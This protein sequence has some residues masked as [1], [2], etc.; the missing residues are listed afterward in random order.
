MGKK[1]IW[2]FIIPI[3]LVMFIVMGALQFVII[4]NVRQRTNELVNAQIKNSSDAVLQVLSTIDLLLKEEVKRSMA[5]LMDKS[6][7]IGEPS[8]NGSTTVVVAGKS[9]P[10]LTFGG[11]AS[12]KPQISMA[13]RF[14][15]VDDV[16]KTMGGTATFFVKSGNDFVRISTNVKKQDGSRAI[17]TLLDPNGKAI[18]EVLA[19]RPFYGEVDI[20]GNPYI[21]GYVPIKNN[22]REALK[23]ALQDTIGIYYV[24]YKVDAM[25]GIDDVVSNATILHN[26]FLAV[27]DGTGKVRFHSNNVT[28]EDIEKILKTSANTVNS[29]VANTTNG[30]TANSTVSSTADGSGGSAE[31]T[32]VG[33]PFTQWGFNVVA[34]YPKKDL[35]SEIFRSVLQAAVVVFIVF[36]VLAVFI[37]VMLSKMILKPLNEV[38]H[39]AEEVGHGNLDLD[40]GLAA[41]GSSSRPAYAPGLTEVS[42]GDEI[43]SLA[44][45]I[46]KMVDSLNEVLSDTIMSTNNVISAMSVVREKVEQSNE[47]IKAQHSQGGQIAA[48]AQ[49]LSSTISNI[50]VN[51][52]QASD[53]STRAM[54]IAVRGKET[55]DGAVDM[56]NTVAGST[57][58]LSTVTKELVGSVNEISGIITVI[59]DIADQTNLLALNAA[60]EAARAG[61]QGRGFAVVADEVRKLAEKTKTAT[62]EISAKI[63][64]VIASAGKTTRSMEAASVGVDKATG[65]MQEVGTSL[66]DIVTAVSA[67]KDQITHIAVAVDEQSATAD[68]ILSSIE[69]TSEISIGMESASM[70]IMSEVDRMITNAGELKKSTGRFRTRRC[71]DNVCTP[72]G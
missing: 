64:A 7:A 58:E 61:E 20:L 62:T 69:K 5:Y 16:A 21:T 34:A 40:V 55:A 52:S 68:E 71:A 51:A 28:P 26:G 37:Y 25:K 36:L 49:E 44:V 63:S 31:W 32:I 41:G 66:N 27:L 70:E 54:E 4:K 2:K 6:A 19:G 53:S 8:L 3:V 22:N 12:G 35:Q 11:G 65:F 24:G 29:S 17:G 10:D 38:V 30:S 14:A 47:G 33:M 59:N 48:A 57:V 42:Y 1:L 43:D 45:S 46:G 23:E 67:V 13:N 39:I 15:L 9:V 56:V 72:S 50:A 18:K 60:I